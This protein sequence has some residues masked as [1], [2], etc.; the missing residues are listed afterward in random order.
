MS[1]WTISTV[2]TGSS[3]SSHQLQPEKTLNKSASQHG[4]V[5]EPRCGP[6]LL[7]VFWP[8]LYYGF[9]IDYGYTWYPNFRGMY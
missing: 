5:T 6:D 7:S 9:S 8:S 3:W 4:A 2:A 1:S